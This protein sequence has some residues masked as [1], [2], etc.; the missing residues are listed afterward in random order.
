V[1]DG[2][3]PVDKVWKH[4]RVKLELEEGEAPGIVREVE[5]H[6]RGGVT[7]GSPMVSGSFPVVLQHEEEEGKL[8]LRG[9]NMGLA[10]GWGSPEREAWSRW[11]LRFRHGERFS[12]G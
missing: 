7:R 11:R 12:D 6:H 9:I 8:R 3:S 1:V 10:A 5:T 4:R 2:D